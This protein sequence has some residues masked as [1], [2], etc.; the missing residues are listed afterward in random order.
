MSEMLSKISDGGNWK[1]ATNTHATVKPL[2]LMSYLCKLVK[3]PGET[4]I[5]DPFMGSG[6]TLLAAMACGAKAIGIES[7]EESCETAVT[8]LTAGVLW[9][10]PS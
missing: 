9:E 8:R 3:M 1:P 4:V 6:T 10:S 2:A 5:L 7:D